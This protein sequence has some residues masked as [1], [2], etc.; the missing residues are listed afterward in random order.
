[1]LVKDLPYK[2]YE[3]ET[4]KNAFEAFEKSANEAK[5][6]KEFLAAREVFLTEAKHYQTMSALANCRFTLNTADEFYQAEMDYYDQNGPLFQEVFVKYGDVM[7]NTPFRSELKK[8]LNPILFKNYE[9]SKKAYNPVAEKECQQEN[10]LCTEYSRFMSAMPVEW[11][12]EK[13]PL[14]FVRGFLSDKDRGVRKQAAFAIGKALE[15][16]KETLDSIYDRLVKIRTEIARKLGYKNF[17]ELG[18]YRMNRI[19]Y[20][21]ADVEKFRANVLSGLVPVVG[22]LKKKLAKKLE[23]SDFSF[24]DDG[25]YSEHGNPKPNGDVKQI[26]KAAQEMYDDMSPE[27]GE[28]MKRMQQAEAFDVES[29][30]NKWGGGYCTGFADYKQ[31]FILANFNGSSDDIDVITHE[32][33]HAFA[34]DCSYKFGDFELDVGGMETAECHS[35]SMEFFAEK[36]MNK[37]FDNPAEYCK[38]HLLS[39]LSFIPYGVIV[40]EFQHIVYDNPDMTPEERD[41]AYLQ[42]EKKYRPYLTFDGIP[43]LEKGTRWQYQMHIYESPF[44][45]ID[46]CLAQ[47]VALGFFIKMAENYDEALSKYLAFVKCGGTKLFPDLVKDAGIADPFGDGTLKTLAEKLMKIA[48]KYE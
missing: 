3:I 9:T 6:A 41:D 20:N 4:F 2:R 47:T 13:K 29:R 22:E 17:T 31:P 32:F 14:A 18:Y 16:N 19:S 27:L 7:L 15:A 10:A 28:F 33:G 25:I 21:R 23:I 8:Q 39:S 26:F 12:G 24:Y 43:Y 30:D 11:N 40:D 46:Y 36:Y 45:Y 1:M 35:M 37:F 5:T 44:Y 38:S 34:A 42:L 48:E